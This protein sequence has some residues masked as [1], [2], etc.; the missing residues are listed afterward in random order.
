[1]PA[2]TSYYTAIRITSL[3]DDAG[4]ADQDRYVFNMKW[5]VFV[6]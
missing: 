6:E 2:N 3:V 5:A 1:M 4:T